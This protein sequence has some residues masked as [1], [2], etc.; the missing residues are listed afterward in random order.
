MKE[1]LKKL[2]YDFLISAAVLE[3]FQGDLKQ[4]IIMIITAD[5]WSWKKTDLIST[6]QG[7][8]TRGKHWRYRSVWFGF[9]FPN[10]P[11]KEANGRM[12]LTLH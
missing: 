6:A 9:F 7:R 10:V 3:A 5:L 12:N 1:N 4:D 2:N 11:N 8:M